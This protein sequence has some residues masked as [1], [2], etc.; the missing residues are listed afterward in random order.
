MIHTTGVSIHGSNSGW[1][2]GATLLLRSSSYPDDQKGGFFLIAA[3]SSSQNCELAGKPDGS[4]T[5]CGRNV[6]TGNSAGLT[7]VAE[8]YSANSWY[9]KYSDG[10]IEQGGTVS[11]TAANIKGYSP[12]VTTNFPVAF[13]QTPTIATIEV[14]PGSL[15]SSSN[16]VRTGRLSLRTTS[17]DSL[18]DTVYYYGVIEASSTGMKIRVTSSNHGANVTATVYYVVVGK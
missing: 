1:L 14:F 15:S 2:D 9:R 3:L 10:W 7:V 8:S 12:T 17:E 18:G 6:L 4:L 13:S 5:W 11:G 16:T